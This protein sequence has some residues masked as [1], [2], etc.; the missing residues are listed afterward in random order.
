MKE[1]L[2]RIIPVFFLI[3]IVAAAI[4]YFTQS[5]DPESETAISASGTIEAVE[6]TISPELSGRVAQVMAKE[7]DAVTA[8]QTLVMLDTALLQAQREQ[9]QAGLQAAQAAAQAADASVNAALAQQSS[10]QAGYEAAASNRDLLQAGALEEQVQAA[11][12]QVDQAQANRQALQATLDTVTQDIRPEALAAARQ[13]LDSARLAYTNMQVFL[14]DDQM[15]DERALLNQAREN[16]ARAQARL[17]G[18][19]SEPDLP[20]SALDSARQD[21]DENTH[22]FKAAD[23][24]LNAIQDSVQP[25]YVQIQLVRQAWDLAQQNLSQARARQELLENTDDMPEAALEAA[26][27]AVEDDTDLVDTAEAAYSALVDEDTAQRLQDAWTEIQNAQQDFNALSRLAGLNGVPPLETLLNQLDAAQAIYDAAAA[28]LALL[29]RG[30][31]QEQ[32]DAAEA[33]LKAAQAQQDAASAQVEMAQA[34]A[35]MAQAQVESAAAA[36]SLIDVQI[37]KLSIGSPVD[38]VVLVRAIEPGEVASPGSS[39]LVIGQ[40]DQLSITVYIPEDRYGEIRLGQTAQVRVDSF[41]QDVFS[42]QVVSIADQAEFTP[43]NV[44]TQEGRRTTV[45][46]VRL[47]VDTADGRLKPGMPADVTF[48]Q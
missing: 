41:P 19:Q 11:R 48:D 25:Y 4:W 1:N 47:D 29:E 14:T 13:R 33:Q 28:N 32:L 22:L 30:T 6:V 26:R 16:L 12:A 21:V 20:D 7:G 17:T 15:E 23:Q 24:A 8:G 43:R 42:G 46:A 2:R 40:L 35:E 36:I 45:F 34:Q 37:A 9:A 3:I 10:A 38:G 18:L 31:R 27:D 39:L 44:Q 5:Q